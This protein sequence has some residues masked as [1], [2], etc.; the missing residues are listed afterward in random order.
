MI[1]GEPI[2]M[3]DLVREFDEGEVIKNV[4]KLREY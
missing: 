2:E 4:E 3:A 1:V